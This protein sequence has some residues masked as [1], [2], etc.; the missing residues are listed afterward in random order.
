MTGEEN[1]FCA[2]SDNG[3]ASVPRRSITPVSMEV[4]IRKSPSGVPTGWTRTGTV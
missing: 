2:D 4:A 1:P 3:T